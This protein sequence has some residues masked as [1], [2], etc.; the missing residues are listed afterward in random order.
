MMPVGRAPNSFPS[1]LNSTNDL[2][3]FHKLRLQKQ[4]PQ[5]QVKTRLQI[6]GNQTSCFQFHL[7]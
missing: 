4:S 2:K 6:S 1:I 3:M 5:L 7:G